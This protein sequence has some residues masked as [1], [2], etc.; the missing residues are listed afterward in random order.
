MIVVCD[1]AE[2]CKSFAV[3]RKTSTKLTGWE[4][5]LIALKMGMDKVRKVIGHE[6]SHNHDMSKDLDIHTCARGL[7]IKQQSQRVRLREQV[8]VQRAN[9]IPSRII[10]GLLQHKPGNV[11]WQQKGRKNAYMGVHRIKC[12]SMKSKWR[13][14]DMTLSL[15]QRDKSAASLEPCSSSASS[16]SRA[17]S[18]YWSALT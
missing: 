2:S 14:T 15:T 16:F 13:T 5:R 3:E 10:S 9:R 17:L 11:L 1:R 4:F 8:C 6:G 18:S 7:T 12:C